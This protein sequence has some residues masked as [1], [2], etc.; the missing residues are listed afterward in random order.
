MTWP[1]RTIFA[2]SVAVLLVILL[3]GAI[4]TPWYRRLPLARGTRVLVVASVIIFLLVLTAWVVFIV[5]I[6][7]D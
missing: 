5:P 1:P 2:V 3:L 4:A 6:Y 7:W